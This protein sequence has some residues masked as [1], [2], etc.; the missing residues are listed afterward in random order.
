ISL[1]LT[2]PLLGAGYLGGYYRGADAKSPDWPGLVAYLRARTLPG[3]L[4]VQSAP[5]PA[6]GYYYGHPADEMSLYPGADFAAKLR[7][8][9][10]FRP[11]I[12]TIDNPPE[13]RAYLGERMQPVSER[14]VG[15]FHVNQFRRWAV[16]A[17]EIEQPAGVVFGDFARL[18]GYT[19]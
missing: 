12:W 6:F 8:E 16:R 14:Q 19:L 13:V 10:N 1:L 17:S 5:D 3:D 18:P 9:I 15:A 11:G 7:P 2:M 4:I